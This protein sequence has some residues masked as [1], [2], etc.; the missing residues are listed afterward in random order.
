MMAQHRAACSAAP[1]GVV[2]P[3]GS[4]GPVPATMIR[5]PSRTAREKPMVA[6]KGEPEVVRLRPVFALLIRR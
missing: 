2:E 5:L 1:P 6:S 3:S 4:T